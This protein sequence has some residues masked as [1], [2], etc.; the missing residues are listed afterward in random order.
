[1]ETLEERLGQR[2][3]RQRRAVGLTQAQLAERVD[4]QPETVSRIE[5][6]NRTASLGLISKIADALEIELHEVFRI[7]DANDPKDRAI[8]RMIWFASRLTQAE[9]DL[10]MDVGTAVLGH[11]RRTHP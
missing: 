6:G 4:I 9:I 8:E 10:V 11:A 1:M 3:A 5:T 7:C 2:L